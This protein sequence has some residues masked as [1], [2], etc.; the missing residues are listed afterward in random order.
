MQPSQGYDQMM[1]AD[2]TLNSSVWC[3]NGFFVPNVFSKVPRYC[4]ILF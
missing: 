3:W 1:S 2:G 4:H